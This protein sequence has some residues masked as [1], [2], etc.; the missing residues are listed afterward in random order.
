MA[1]CKEYD[2]LL[3]YRPTPAHYIMLQD[4]VAEAALVLSERGLPLDDPVLAE[5]SIAAEELCIEFTEQMSAYVQSSGRTL[6]RGR[7]KHK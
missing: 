7:P 4:G 3:A 6:S 2:S 1:I 5:K